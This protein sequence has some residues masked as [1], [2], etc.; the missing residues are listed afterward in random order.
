MPVC[1]KC[2][3]HFPYR[4]HIKGKWRV[5]NKRRYCLRCSPFGRHNTQPLHKLTPNA[6]RVVGEHLICGC[7]RKYKYE[8]RKGHTKARCNS[9]AV[10]RKRFE[11]KKVAVSYKGGQCQRCGY[12]RCLEALQFHHRDPSKKDFSLSSNH[13]LRWAR[14]QKELDKCDLVCCR[15]HVEI[16]YELRH[17]A[18][19]SSAQRKIIR[20]QDTV[21]QR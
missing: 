20:E 17:S 11:L 7:G 8:K 3:D 19:T 21:A 14:I 9:C 5:L 10:N 16:H 6:A 13:C 12:S 2:S 4:K 1:A 15:C 18:N